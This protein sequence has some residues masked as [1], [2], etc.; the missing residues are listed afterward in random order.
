MGNRNKKPKAAFNPGS[1]KIPRH[2]EEVI[3]YLTL[4]P[5]W[6]I[7]RIDEQGR[8]GWNNI[9]PEEFQNEV[10]PKFKNFE[11]NTWADILGDHNHEV[12]ISKIDKDAQKRLAQLKIEDTESLVSLRLNNKKRIWG[13]RSVA[14]FKI[15]WWDPL[16]EVYPSPL[17]HT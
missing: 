9:R 17:K 8:W 4:K 6:Q 16:H 1:E 14:V 13:I 10:I 15:L 5:S 7:S 11:S 2:K 12:S 3:N